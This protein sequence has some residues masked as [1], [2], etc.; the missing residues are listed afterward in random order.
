MLPPSLD[1][2]YAQWQEREEIARAGQPLL[3][4]KII[5]APCPKTPG[6]PDS[7]PPP[8]PLLPQTPPML[9]GESAQHNYRATPRDKSSAPFPIYY[10]GN[11]VPFGLHTYT[12]YLMDTLSDTVSVA[13][14]DVFVACFLVSLRPEL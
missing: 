3:R 13:G 10:I 2:N 14:N 8:R 4:K 6:E 1:H 11:M 5:P 12:K 9:H 7:P